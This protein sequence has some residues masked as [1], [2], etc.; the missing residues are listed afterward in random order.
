M[1][2]GRQNQRI[3]DK[4]K[5]LLC[6]KPNTSKHINTSKKQNNLNVK[7]AVPL[8]THLRVSHAK[9]FRALVP[10]TWRESLNKNRQLWCQNHFY[11]ISQYGRTSTHRHKEIQS[12]HAC[13]LGSFSRVWLF[14]SPWTIAH[15]APLSMRLSRQEYWSGLPGP[16]P[17]DLPDPGTKPTSLASLVSPALAGRRFTTGAS[18]EAHIIKGMYV[19]RKNSTWLNSGS[20]NTRYMHSGDIGSI[21]LSAADWKPDAPLEMDLCRPAQRHEKISLR[22]PGLSGR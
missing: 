2:L 7:H 12:K 6:R 17:G 19:T 3:K 21:P 16:A 5:S 8:Q 10:E 20:Q 15:Q 22:Y 1:P 4:F 9:S 11:W 13:V 14:V 18:W